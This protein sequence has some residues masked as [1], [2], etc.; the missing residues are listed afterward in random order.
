MLARTEADL[1]VKRPI[2]SEQ[3][4]RGDLPVTRHLDLGQQPLDLP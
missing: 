1:K 3:A 4:R 2:L